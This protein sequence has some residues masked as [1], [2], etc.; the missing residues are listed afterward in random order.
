VEKNEEIS[1]YKMKELNLWFDHGLGDCANFAY[2]LEIYRRRGFKIN[3]HCPDDKALVFAPVIA[4]RISLDHPG[5]T[6]V[7]YPESVDPQLDTVEQYWLYNKAGVNVAGEPLPDIGSAEELWDELS[8]IRLRAA[9]HI[10][11]D[12]WDRVDEFLR[13]LPRPIVLIHSMGTTSAE[14]KNIPPDVAIELYKEL[15]DRIDGT[16]VLLDWDDRVPRLSNWRVRHMTDDWQWI[17]VSTLVALMERS[18]LLISVDS[19]PLHLSRMTKIPTIGVFPTLTKFPARVSLPKAK[20]VNIVSG[21]TMHEYNR[22]T[23]IL[24]NIVESPGS[25]AI[26]PSFI[27]DIAQRMLAEPRYLS[28]DLIGA[29]VQLQQFVLDWERGAGN[30]LTDYNDRHRGWDFLLKH[31][32][33]HFSHPIFV[34]TGCIRGIEDWRG[35]GFG[36]YLMGAFT[37]RYGGEVI[38]VDIDEENCRFAEDM[39]SEMNTVTIENSD[40]ISFLVEFGRSIDVLV[41]DSM[42]TEIPGYQE[43]ALNE[44]VTGMKWLHPQSIVMFDDTVYEKGKF[45]G[46]GALGVPWLLE[47]G[48][49]IIHSGY[50]TICAPAQ[51]KAKN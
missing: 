19:G 17:E 35:A 46:K 18:D 41:L 15:L 40:S 50:Q 22:K 49:S 14:W 43:H 23:R 51:V 37:H 16:L 11:Q 30:S 1:G 13:E 5:L 20:T 26:N 33:S 12:D 8:N 10:D 29:D 6:Y 38:S 25:A 44:I 3:L 21:E 36:T 24:Y 31:V 4:N 47:Q 27:A 48:W 39:T 28:A 42:D 2:I 32:R 9:S 45:V 34:E 7:T